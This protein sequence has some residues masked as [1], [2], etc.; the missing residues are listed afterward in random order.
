MAIDRTEYWHDAHSALSLDYHELELELHETRDNLTHLIDALY[1]FLEDPEVPTN[2]E[3]LGRAL[4]ASLGLLNG[5]LA[6]IDDL[7]PA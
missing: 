7:D 6:E 2:V 4:R 5:H 1:G 3:S